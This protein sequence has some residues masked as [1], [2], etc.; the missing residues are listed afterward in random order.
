[1]VRAQ[2]L[3]HNDQ[4]GEELALVE[5]RIG[6]VQTEDLHSQKEALEKRLVQLE[7]Q[8]AVAR[9]MLRQPIESIDVTDA[10]FNIAE[11]CGVEIMEIS[12]PGL[13]SEKLNGIN[14]PT[15]Q[16]VINVEGDVPDLINFIIKLNNDFVTG[17]VT[18]ARIGVQ[19]SDEGEAG[20]ESDEGEAGDESDEGE[21]GEES[22]EGEAGE[23]SD[24]GEAGEESDEGEAGEESDE[25]EADEELVEEEPERSSASINLV[26]YS[27][28][29]E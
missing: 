29:G 3:S 9:D 27:Y 19:E 25:G 5:T 15:A 8:Y 13:T 16:F 2:Q 21:A 23:E 7:S 24:E 17:I 1:M 4:L 26:V 18:S 28:Q 22:D 6:Q 12:S 10:I 20:E 11:S 14:C